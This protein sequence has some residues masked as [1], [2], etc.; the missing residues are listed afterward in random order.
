MKTTK[1]YEK[2]IGYRMFSACSNTFT[3]GYRK[4][5]S[6]FDTDSL[7]SREDSGSGFEDNEWL[8]YW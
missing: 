4:T 5:R 6:S 8:A 3:S 2:N 1:F 7:F